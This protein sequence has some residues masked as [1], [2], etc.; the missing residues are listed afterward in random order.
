MTSSSTTSRSFVKASKTLAA[1]AALACALCAGACAKDSTS[2]LT[3]IEADP[4]APPVLLLQARIARADDPTRVSSSRFTSSN[5]GDAGDRPGPFVFPF[6]MS[7]T[8]DPS[9]AGPVV[10]TVE[11]LDWDTNTVIASGSTPADVVAQHETQAVVRL[12]RP[13]AP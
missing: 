8:V 13:S 7:L 4:A 2:V 3:V 1:A 6:A 11:G 5:L 10:V 12:L 9:F